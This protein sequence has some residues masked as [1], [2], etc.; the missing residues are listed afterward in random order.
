MQPIVYY[1]V[2]AVIA[3]FG[4]GFSVGFNIRKK[5]PLVL[6]GVCAQFKDVGMFPG[7]TSQPV[8]TYPSNIE[9]EIIKK[10]SSVVGLNCKHYTGIGCNHK[11]CTL[12]LCYLYNG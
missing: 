5:P 4:L 1:F 12:G 11:D 6:K 3:A 2:A 7:K 8:T 9:I 10:G